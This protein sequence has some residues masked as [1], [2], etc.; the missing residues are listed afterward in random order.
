MTQE[1]PV[2]AETAKAP[3]GSAARLIQVAKIGRAH[4]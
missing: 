2:P 1:F 4:V 3:N